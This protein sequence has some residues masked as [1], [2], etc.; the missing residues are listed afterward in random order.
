M[1]KFSMGSPN[2]RKASLDD[3]EFAYRVKRTGLRQY[4]K[5]V[6]GWDEDQERRLH[7]RR[8]REQDFRIIEVEGNDVGIMSFAVKPD[9]LFVYQ[10]YLL[11]E[12]QGRGIGRKCMLAVME[13]GNNLGLPIRLRVMKVNTRA[14]TFYQRLGFEIT[15]VTD[16]H[17]LMQRSRS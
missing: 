17:F 7:A 12:R 5:Q 11:P 10:L 16:A 1:T 4:V 14:V 6:W 8:F 9:C 13:Q 2:L 15:D 3:E